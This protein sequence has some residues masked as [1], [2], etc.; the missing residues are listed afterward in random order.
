MNYIFLCVLIIIKLFV[1]ALSSAVFKYV[2]KRV[3]V[4]AFF[5]GAINKI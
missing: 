3:G 4:L 2:A 5:E 1:T